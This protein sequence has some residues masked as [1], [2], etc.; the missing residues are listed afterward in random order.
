VASAPPHAE[1]CSGID[2]TIF[3][4]AASQAMKLPMPPWLFGAGYMLSVAPT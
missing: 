3:P 2:Q 4:A 1:N